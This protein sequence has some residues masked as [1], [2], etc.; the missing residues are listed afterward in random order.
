VLH[1]LGLSAVHEKSVDVALVDI[2]VL[3]VLADV[4]VALIEVVAQVVARA[5]AGLVAAVGVV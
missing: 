2:V 3:L 4:V 1:C 5:I